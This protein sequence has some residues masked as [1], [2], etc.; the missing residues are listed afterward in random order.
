LGSVS[1]SVSFDD[2]TEEE[3]LPLSSLLPLPRRSLYLFTAAT[4][5]SSATTYWRLL[6]SL[7]AIVEEERECVGE[8]SGLLM[9]RE[10]LL[11]FI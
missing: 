5:S 1:A 7:E 10:P 9:R 11:R 4:D 2:K 3:L 6:L 8:E